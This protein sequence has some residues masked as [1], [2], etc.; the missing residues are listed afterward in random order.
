MSETLPWLCIHPTQQKKQPPNVQ[1]TDS[2]KHFNLKG[3]QYDKSQGTK[4]K[5]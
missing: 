5:S 2:I 3:W 1:S 4:Y